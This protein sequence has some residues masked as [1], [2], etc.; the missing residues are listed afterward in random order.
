MGLSPRVPAVLRKHVGSVAEDM[1]AAHGLRP[2]DVAGWAVHPGGP[3]IVEA[4]SK[5]LKLSEEQ[6]AQLVRAKTEGPE[7]LG[8]DP[9]SGLP[10]FMLMGRFGPYVQLGEAR[11]GEKPR[12]ASLPKGMTPDALDL[13]TALRLLSLPRV[14]G[15]HPESGKPI[16]AGV[17][18]FGPFVVHD[19]DF[20]SLTPGDDVYTVPI[21]RALELLSQAKGVKRGATPLRDIGPHPTDGA[22][23]QLFEGRFGPYVKHGTVN[24]SLAKGADPDKLTVADA[25]RLLE[26]RIAKGDPPGKGRKSARGRKSAPAR[27]AAPVK[28]A[29]AARKAAPA[30]RA[31]AAAK[32]ARAVKKK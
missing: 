9:Q 1:L 13:P 30:K 10:V 4:V 21:Q 24:A 23:I 16:E 26:E 20:R 17:G 29:A 15:A 7:T 27:K 31:G 22:P 19:G 6:V 14:L 28:K 5:R 18:R 11:E 12:R 25:V 2:A 3:R 32:K 8:I